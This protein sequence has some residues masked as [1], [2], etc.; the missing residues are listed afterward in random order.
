MKNSRIGTITFLALDQH[1]SLELLAAVGKTL[2][3]S[4]D[5]IHRAV[6]IGDEAGSILKILTDYDV[7]VESGKVMNVATLADALERISSTEP[8]YHPLAGGNTI[9]V[10]SAEEMQTAVRALLP[11]LYMFDGGEANR[12]KPGEALVVAFE[13]I[14][15][16]AMPFASDL[17]TMP[18]P[19]RVV[20][21]T[22]DAL[23]FAN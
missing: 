14:P 23:A 20:H 8:D 16:G 2:S 12:I 1:V 9:L 7:T 13:L 5:V 21:E 4:V 15:Q 18:M 6:A 11:R 3:D 22:E 17:V 19:A 10:G